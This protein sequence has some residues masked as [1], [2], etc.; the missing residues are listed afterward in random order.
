MGHGVCET[1]E[2]I[3]LTFRRIEIQYCNYV[4]VIDGGPASNALLSGKYQTG[5][6]IGRYVP[7]VEFD[8]LQE[9]E[10]L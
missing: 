2:H 6:R 3:W 10:R 4:T 1:L 8:V 9:E 7:N 5:K